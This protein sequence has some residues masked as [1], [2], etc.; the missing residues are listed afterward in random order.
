MVSR[1]RNAE[2]THIRDWHKPFASFWILHF[3]EHLCPNTS[4][5]LTFNHWMEPSMKVLVKKWDETKYLGSIFKETKGK[6]ATSLRTHDRNHW[7]NLHQSRLIF[8]IQSQLLWKFCRKIYFIIIEPCDKN[9]V[10]NKQIEKR[11]RIWGFENSYKIKAP[12]SD[13]LMILSST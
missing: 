5:F 4:T 7:H 2:I 9:S 1:G 6:G 3:P 11:E 10:Q 8:I 13:G 12:R